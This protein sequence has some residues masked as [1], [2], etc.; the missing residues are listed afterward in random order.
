MTKLSCFAKRKFLKLLKNIQKYFV[1]IKLTILK[2]LRKFKKALV[3]KPVF[4]SIL[5]ICVLIL[6]GLTYLITNLYNES[7]ILLEQRNEVLNTYNKEKE[8]LK[9]KNIESYA[10][11]LENAFTEEQILKIITKVTKYSISIN[12]KSLSKN[13][14]TFYS[15]NKKTVISFYEKYNRD[16]I[17]LVTLSLLR[18][19]SKISV[20]NSKNLIKIYTNNATYKIS[21]QILDDGRKLIIQFDNIGDGEIITL[22]IESGFAKILGLEVNSIE[23]F[24]NKT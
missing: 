16:A 8:L 13:E 9:T 4:Y 1:I 19:Y 3:N 14:E 11:R 6:S 24:H 7:N 23:I 22:D 21:E 15:N 10:S 17:D 5:I 20:L 18:K 12:N 2:K